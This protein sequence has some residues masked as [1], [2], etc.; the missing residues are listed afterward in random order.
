MVHL[1]CMKILNHSLIKLLLIISVLFGLIFSFFKVQ[2]LNRI[3]SQNERQYPIEIYEN[4]KSYAQYFL[5][6]EYDLK[7][8]RNKRIQKIV[9][10]FNEINNAKNDINIKRK[11][12]LQAQLGKKLYLNLKKIVLL[13]IKISEQKHPI[14][15]D[16]DSWDLYFFEKASVLNYLENLQAP[17][18]NNELIRKMKHE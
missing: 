11:K 18:L 10:N 2:E 6:S 8:E 7:K 16:V 15:S 17:D 3:E 14:I 12:M 9:N 4:A 1:R 13:L 5:Y